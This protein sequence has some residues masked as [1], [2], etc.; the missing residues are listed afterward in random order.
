MKERFDINI[1]EVDGAGYV[2]W[3]TDSEHWLG[4]VVRGMEKVQ[5]A[6]AEVGEGGRGM[7]FVSPS[8]TMSWVP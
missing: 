7:Y 3:Y 5:E 6:G 1:W 8:G 2:D 4:Q